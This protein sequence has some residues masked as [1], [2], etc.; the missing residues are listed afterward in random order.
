MTYDPDS[1]ARYFDTL[2]E[3]EWLRLESTLQGR[4]KYAVHRHFVERHIRPGMHVLDVGSGPGR[5][6]LD[7]V[8][9][10]ADVTLVDLSPVQLAAA[11]E[12]MA[13]RGV[14]NRV[15][16][17]HQLDVLDM[18]SL[19]ADSYDAVLCFGGAI[20]YT[21]ERHLDALRQLARVARPGAPILLSVMSLYGVMGLVGPLDAATVLENVNDHLD[22]DA[23]L[24][25][26]GVVFTRPTSTEFHQPLALFSSAGLR[27][28]L[29]EAGLEVRTL[30]SA[31]PF[32][33]EFLPVPKIEASERAA[34]MLV[35]LEVALCDQ[36]GLVDTGSHL[37]AVAIKPS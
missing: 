16:G 7:C 11:R 26:A 10:G 19:A 20:S 21:K 15:R 32:L 12:R 23:V 9:L 27:S 25:G 29:V 34:R 30:A 2:A 6:G 13:V 14:L 4:I 1:V 33:P 36:P 22:W 3:Q 35:D 17:F 31:N 8:A 28:A 18:T 24:S 5:F 37:L